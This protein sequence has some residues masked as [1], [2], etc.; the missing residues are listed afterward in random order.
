MADV[1]NKTTNQYLMSVNTP[2]FDPAEW[3][4][5]PD[6]S[7]V[8]DTDPALWIVENDAVRVLTKEEIN[9]SKLDQLKADLKKKVNAIRDK[10]IYAGF[11]YDKSTIQSDQFSIIKIIGAS[12]MA[13]NALNRSEDLPPDFV[14]RDI[15]NDPIPVDA[16]KMLDLGTS[17]FNYVW[18]VH[19]N[20][21]FHK[22]NID[23]ITDYD[24]LVSYD[25]NTG[26]PT[27]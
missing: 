5:N 27:N 7:A 19:K 12:L 2:D 14:W 10:L 13:L 3:I 9:S 20:S 17:L 23:A 21:W 16:N 24:V 25:I 11:V 4:I 1:L 8:K 26:W 22:N 15:N 6:L 18:A